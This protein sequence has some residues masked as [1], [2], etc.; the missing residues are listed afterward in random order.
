MTGF[1]R[2]ELKAGL[3][4]IRVEI[5]TTNH[6]FLEVSSRLP[7]HLT[8]FEDKIR[9][10][11]SEQ[12]RRGKVHLF[13]SSPD[14]ETQGSKL[15]LNEAL[16][17]EVSQHIKRLKKVLDLKGST[18]DREDAIILKEV[19]HYPNVLTRDIS[20]NSNGNFA[21]EID[22]AVSVALRN[23]NESRKREGLA[24]EKDF[25][26]RTAE[27]DKSLT[28][29]EKRVPLVSKEYKH[30]LEK[31]IKEHLE[32]I[33]VDKERLTIEVAQFIKNSDISEEITRLRSHIVEMKKT[34]KET[35]EIGRKIDFIG[36]EMY[37]ESN[38][39]GAKSNDMIIASNVI[40]LKSAVEKIREQ[41]QNVE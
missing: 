7:F 5:K 34:L 20:E 22:K 39:I 14:P 23:L 40:A 30:S 29:I 11:I 8:E 31:K 17:R 38:T 26:K 4:F 28:V 36:Q 18:R 41:S 21:K 32:D 25:L 13:I 6:K 9:K 16:A 27:I 33:P 3:G 10:L 15:V 19:L 35:G 24:L 37:R 1:G 2:S 12:V